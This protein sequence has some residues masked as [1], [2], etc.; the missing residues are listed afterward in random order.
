MMKLGSFIPR[1]ES[2]IIFVVV[3][4]CYTQT[5]T[6]LIHG[7]LIPF[8]FDL[9]PPP[10]AAPASMPFLQIA[11]GVIASPL[12]ESAILIGLIELLDPLWLQVVVATVGIGLLHSFSTLNGHFA[13]WSMRGVLVGARFRNTKRRLRLLASDIS[14]DSFRSRIFN[15][16]AP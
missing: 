14:R 16:C 11:E 15:S 1:S 7:V 12:V 9:A 6:A 13:S 4:V 5:L 3:M 10:F 2:K 8:H